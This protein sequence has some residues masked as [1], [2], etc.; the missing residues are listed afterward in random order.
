MFEK[1]TVFGGFAVKDTDK[2]RSFYGTTLGLDVRDGSQPGIL[3][4][5]GTG[6]SPILVY[7]KPDHKPATFTVLNIDVPDIERA[8]G[9]LNKSG[10][11]MEHYDEDPIV[12]DQNGILRGGGMAV[13]WFKDPFGSILSIIENE[14]ASAS[15]S[16]D[17]RQM[18]DARR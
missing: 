16:T 4:I 10:V 14:E 13:A 11:R 8:V 17:G 12:T 9:D 7:P 3:E 5:H 15:S 18:A 1:R 6:G 2:A